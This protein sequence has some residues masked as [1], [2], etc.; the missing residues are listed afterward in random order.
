MRRAALPIAL[1]IGIYLDSILFCRLNISGIRPDALLA[2]VVSAGVLLGS[3]KGGLLGVGI[4]LFMDVLFGKCVGLS[5]IAYMVAGR[6]RRNVLPEVLCRQCDCPG[7]GCGC[8]RALKGAHHDVGRAAFRR[9][10]FLC[11]D[12]GRVCAALHAADCSAYNARA[13]PPQARACAPGSDGAPR[14]PA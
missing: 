10:V 12:G 13:C 14:R 3:V 6:G 11:G 8:Q 9:D 5:A 4:G 2:V 1:L 7:W